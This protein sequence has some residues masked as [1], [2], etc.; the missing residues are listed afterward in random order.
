MRIS[1]RR[2]LKE[3]KKGLKLPVRSLAVCFVIGYAAAGVGEADI[4]VSKIG[5]SLGP[6]ES[7]VCLGPGDPKGADAESEVRCR[8]IRVH[9]GRSCFINALSSLLGGGVMTST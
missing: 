3:W 5:I 9:G 6:P 1:K 7:R 4:I 8:R 2:I